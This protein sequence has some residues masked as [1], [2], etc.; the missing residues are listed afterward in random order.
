MLRCRRV[1]RLRQVQDLVLGNL[2][3]ARIRGAL[4]HRVVVGE[5]RL[6]GRMH[7]MVE[8]GVGAMG[9]L[10]HWG[11]RRDELGFVLRVGLVGGERAG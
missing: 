8:E 7:V 6:V 11:G 3:G 9:G 2:E 5:H 1:R 4:H 10:W